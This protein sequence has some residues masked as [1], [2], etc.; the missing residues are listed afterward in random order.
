M[1]IFNKIFGSKQNK[2]ITEKQKLPTIEAFPLLN[3]NDR[4]SVI[5]IVG[6]SG[7]LD[8]FHFLKFAIVNDKDTGVRF[9]AL[10]RIHLFKNHPETIPMILTLK[11]NGEGEK[12][13]PY[14]SMALSR[15]GNISLEEF[16]NQINDL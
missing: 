5:M 10:K 2:Q 3:D 11:N 12:L 8:Y 14:F 9:A 6:D 4:M 13:E 7:N 1:S 16:K 15:L